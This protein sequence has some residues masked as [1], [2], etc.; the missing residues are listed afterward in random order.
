MARHRTDRERLGHR[1]AVPIVGRQPGLCLNG[2][3]LFTAA[4]SHVT[5]VVGSAAGGRKALTARGTCWCLRFIKVLWLPFSGLNPL[6]PH[7]KRPGDAVELHVEAAGVAHGLTL[8]VAAPQRGG[9]GLAVGTGEAH[10]AGGGQSALG[11]D[12]GPVDPIHLVVEAAG[13][14]QIVPCPV[15]PPEWGGHGPTVDTLSAF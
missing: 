5:G 6:F 12:E 8:G 7:R 4:G 3:H 10:S 9:G 1:A 2:A 13:I 15:P 14:A 11:L